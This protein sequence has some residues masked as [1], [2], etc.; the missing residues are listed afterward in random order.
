[1]IRNILNGGRYDRDLIVSEID[2]RMPGHGAISIMDF[3]CSSGRVLRHFYAEQQSNGWLLHGVDIQ[4]RPIEW[5][6]Q[7]FPRNF[8]VYTGS[9]MPHLPF[10]EFD[11]RRDLWVQHIHTH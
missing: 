5:M 10:P 2:A 6:R 9:T 1:M 7:N 3:G 8:C 4:A 11:F